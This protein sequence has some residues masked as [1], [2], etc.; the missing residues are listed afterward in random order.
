MSSKRILLILL[1]SLSF[2]FVIFNKIIFLFFSKI[3][4]LYIIAEIFNGCCY[5]FKKHKFSK[6]K[7]TSK[8]NWE[9]LYNYTKEQIEKNE[10]T[11]NQYMILNYL[12]KII[13]LV[14]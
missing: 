3:F 2:Y 4:K 13:L 8:E 6:K 1:L 11:D 12:S 10:L 9:E 7:T 5:I 14:L